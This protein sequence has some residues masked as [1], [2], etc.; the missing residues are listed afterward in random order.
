M[1][2]FFTLLYTAIIV[3]VCRL[4]K[5]PV[6]TVGSAGHLLCLLNGLKNVKTIFSFQAV[7]KQALAKI[8]PV[9]HT[10]GLVYVL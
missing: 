3:G 6:N 8:W 5:G 10:P 1:K 2:R 4:F 7:D 9:G